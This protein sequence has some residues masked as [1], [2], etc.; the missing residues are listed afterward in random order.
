MGI[1]KQKCFKCNK[2][3]YEKDLFNFDNSGYPFC[4]NCIKEMKKKGI[5]VK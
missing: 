4:K 2:W 5:K 3:F 1:N